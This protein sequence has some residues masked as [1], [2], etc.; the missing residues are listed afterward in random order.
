M[1]DERLTVGRSILQV[2]DGVVDVSP[3]ALVDAP[4]VVIA[5]SEASDWSLAS[6]KADVGGPVP[7]SHPIP[8]RVIAGDIVC[9]AIRLVQVS[10]R[11]EIRH[12]GPGP[13][14]IPL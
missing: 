8:E 10:S 14:S 4:L 7:A 12:V 11:L 1:K 6:V 3:A 5:L 13:F 9:L 2:S